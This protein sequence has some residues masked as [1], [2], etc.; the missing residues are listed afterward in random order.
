[1]TA[2]EAREKTEYRILR[3][4]LEFKAIYKP[5]LRK[6]QEVWYAVPT[7]PRVYESVNDCSRQNSFRIAETGMFLATESDL[8]AWAEEHPYI[9]DWLAELSQIFRKHNEPVYL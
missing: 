3:G 5:W 4:V 2:V 7:V 8:R 6:P 1:M 9:D